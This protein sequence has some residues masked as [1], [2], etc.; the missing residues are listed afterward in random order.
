MR[1]FGFGA[2]TG[3]PLPGESPGIVPQV[4]DYSGSSIGNLPIGQGLAVTPIQMVAR[5]RRDRQRRQCWSKPRLVL[6]DEPG[7]GRR[8]I[9]RRTAA[10][11]AAMLEGVL[12]PDGHRARGGGRRLRHRA[13]RPAP[14][15]RPRT[16]ATPR[17]QFVASFIGFA[18]AATPRLLVAVI[19]DEPRAHTGGEVA[20]PAFEKIASFA[21]PYLG[22]APE[23]APRLAAAGR[24]RIRAAMTLREL[25]AGAGDSTRAVAGGRRAIPRST[26]ACLPQRRASPPGALFFCVPGFSADGHDFAPEAVER[27]AAALVCERPLGLGV[28]EVVVRDVRAAMGPLAARVLRAPDRASCA[29]S[30]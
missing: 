12:G 18:P 28:P 27:G 30:A 1:R 24:P 10:R 25:I 21:L 14:P 22:I 19:V 29:W 15:R 7:D 6:D 2:P 4:E 9:S 17:T 13:A 26:G 5:L 20:A 8:V 3:L 16:A 11:V 23:V